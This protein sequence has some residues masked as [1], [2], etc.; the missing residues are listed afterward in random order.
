MPVLQKKANHSKKISLVALLTGLVSLSVVLTVTI[1][2]IS[3]YQSKKQALIHT[4]LTLN[5]TSALKMS[6]TIDALIK[7]MR[8]S[9][10]YSASIFFDMHA[11]NANEI[12]EKLELIRRTN[13]YFNSITVV[14]ETGLVRSVSPESIGTEG[15]YLRTT[16]AKTILAKKSLIFLYHT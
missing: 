16:A 7:S 6:H 3:F 1:L 4:T 8:S 5:H 2:L 13:N 9:L 10:Q 12:H 11:M 14:D 15:T